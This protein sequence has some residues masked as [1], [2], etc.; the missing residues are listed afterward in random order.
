[1]IAARDPGSDRVPEDAESQIANL[2][3]HVDAMLRLLAPTGVTSSG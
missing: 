2:F 1:M 3:H